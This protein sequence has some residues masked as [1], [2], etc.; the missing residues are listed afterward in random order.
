MERA[1]WE[2]CVVRERRLEALMAMVGGSESEENG[3]GRQGREGL[4]EVAGRAV[5]M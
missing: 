3:K 5:I 2:G 4:E 1:G